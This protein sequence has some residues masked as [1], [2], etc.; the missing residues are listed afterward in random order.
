MTSHEDFSR[1]EGP[2]AS[3]DRAFGVV[4]AIFFLLIGLLPWLRAREPRWWCLV[5]SGACLAVALARP[6]LL[7][8]ANIV[9]TR[10]AVIL[11]KIV[12]PMVTSLLFYLV[13]TPSGILIRMG[14]KD[15]LRLR[16]DPHT[17]SYWNE[18]Q[19]PGPP[20]KSMAQ[21]F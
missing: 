16:F 14:G 19:P 8:P 13:F 15:L 1:A 2:L 6:A 7:H 17:K 12:N 20:P 4:L 9:W 18:R 21:Q 3:P 10:L 11:N 5:V